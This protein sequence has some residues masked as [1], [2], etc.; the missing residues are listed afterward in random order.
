MLLYDADDDVEERVRVVLIVE[1][2][3]RIVDFVD[4]VLRDGERDMG[5]E[6][7]SWKELHRTGMDFSWPILCDPCAD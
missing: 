4:V 3:D 1:V 5:A 2:V 7:Y 6:E